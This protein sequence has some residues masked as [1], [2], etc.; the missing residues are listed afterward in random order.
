MHWT[1]LPLLFAF[2]YNF[3][4]SLCA[5]PLNSREILS[6][7]NYAIQNCEKIG[8]ST[9]ILQ[10]VPQLQQAL[11]LVLLDLEHGTASRHGFRAFLK[12]NANVPVVREVFQA[13]A[14]GSDVKTYKPMIECL[15]PEGLTPEQLAVYRMLCA[16]RPGFEAVS[17]G[18]LPI[19]GLVCLCP[20]FWT[21]A[22]FPEVDDC[23]TV[24][25]RRGQRRFVDDDGGFGETQFAVLV[26]ELVHL[27]NP[28]D[29][30]LEYAEV[31]S[32]Q[33][34]V[35]L[36]ARQSVRNAENWA[37]YA[38]GES[39]LQVWFLRDWYCLSVRESISLLLLK[40][41]CVQLSK[42]GV[43]DFPLRQLGENCS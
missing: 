8:R 18:A 31:Y 15:S 19:H 6:S 11:H 38:A 3:H 43:L 42:P 37:L 13:I 5:N 33:E 41:I 12:S 32:A 10:L 34:C 36:D 4:A 17:A 27:Y 24:S 14:N 28:I 39:L 7:G 22:A 23:P 16:T 35:E 25:G 2:T 1:L 40:L 26:H 20:Y 30:G 29:G 21:H 9:E